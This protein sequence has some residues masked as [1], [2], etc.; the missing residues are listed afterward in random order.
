MD[1]YKID[2]KGAVYGLVIFV[3]LWFDYPTDLD[4]YNP[5]WVGFGARFLLALSIAWFATDGRRKD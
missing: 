2:R 4:R 5:S 1:K 3:V